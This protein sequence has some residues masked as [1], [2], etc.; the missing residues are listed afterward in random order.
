MYLKNNAFLGISSNISKRISRQNNLIFTYLEISQ[1]SYV[2]FRDAEYL[3]TGMNTG[4]NE[5]PAESLPCGIHA[6]L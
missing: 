4:R 5:Y 2:N 6:E 3:P 1:Q